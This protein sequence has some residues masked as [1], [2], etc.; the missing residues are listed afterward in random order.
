MKKAW[1]APRRSMPGHGL[2]NAYGE[3]G[4]GISASDGGGEHRVEESDVGTPRR[5][6]GGSG[7]YGVDDGVDVVANETR[8]RATRRRSP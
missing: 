6:S 3:N 7:S 8:D 5:G 2:V 1:I 4:A